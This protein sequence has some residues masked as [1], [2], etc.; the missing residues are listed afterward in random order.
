MS[1]THKDF[2]DVKSL[3][4]AE[5]ALAVLTDSAMGVP[6]DPDTVHGLST[7][8]SN[9]IQELAGAVMSLSTGNVLAL[10]PDSS[11]AMALS[12]GEALIEAP[13]RDSDMVWLHVYG[14][15]YHSW[16]EGHTMG[17][18]GWDCHSDSGKIDYRLRRWDTLSHS[19]REKVLK[20]WRD[21]NRPVTN[22]ERM[23]AELDNV[24][25]GGR[26]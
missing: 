10:P 3:S 18:E 7:I 17:E 19:Q 14:Y 25:G 23:R 9:M 16:Y 5:E 1:L 21:P 15:E 20:A 22:L 24:R 13:V 11:L 4:R 2:M 26:E 8:V 6:T 12:H